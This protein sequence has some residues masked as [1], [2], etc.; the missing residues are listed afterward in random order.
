M[1]KVLIADDEISIATLISDSLEDEGIETIIVGNGREVLLQIEKESFDLIILDIM[2][3]EMDGIE[4]CRRIRD[5]VTCPIIFVTAKNRTLDTLVG[6][7]IGADDYIVKPFVVEEL[8]AKV[9]A[10]IRR[11]K[12]KM[13]DK[14]L[15]TVGELKIFPENYE[16]YKKDKRIDLTT[17]EFQLL[18]YFCSNIGKV[19]TREQIFDAVWG[20]DYSDIGTVT[21]TLKNL[22]DKIDKENEYLK[23][24]WGVGYKFIKPYGDNL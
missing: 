9:K 18:M 22:R 7:E 24:V 19:L 16:V 8:V 10:H 17:R 3:P 11:D 6:L 1:S 23:T 14:A 5:I 20:S 4:V 13:K 12:R 15:I 2:M 21:V